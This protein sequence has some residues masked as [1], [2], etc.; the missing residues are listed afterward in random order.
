MV[1]ESSLFNVIEGLL[2]ILFTILGHQLFSYSNSLLVIIIDNLFYFRLLESLKA[3]EENPVFNVLNDVVIN[4][5][6]FFGT[7]K[8]LLGIFL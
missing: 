1:Q 3:L 8:P 5:L 2:L 4:V 7:I 6:E